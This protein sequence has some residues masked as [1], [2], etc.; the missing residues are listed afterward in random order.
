MITP[1]LMFGLGVVAIA[2]WFR[3]LQTSPGRRMEQ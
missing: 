3:N 2:K 1:E